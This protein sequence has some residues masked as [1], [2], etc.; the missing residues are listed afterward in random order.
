MY[1]YYTSTDNGQRLV[2]Q[3]SPYVRNLGVFI[4]AD[5]VMRSHV[6]R[7][8]A[9]CFVVLR[10]LRLI[11]RLLS[12]TTLNTMVVALVLSRLDYHL[13]VCCQTLED[14]VVL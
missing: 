11:S 14:H 12:P 10:H 3:S 13:G 5:L 4:D 9:Q 1:F 8:V 2:S 6:T 7:V